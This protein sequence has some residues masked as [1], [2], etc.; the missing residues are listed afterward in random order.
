[1]TLSFGAIRHYFLSSGAGFNQEIGWPNLI[2]PL[3]LE[4]HNIHTWKNAYNSRFEHVDSSKIDGRKV[5][6]DLGI[7][8]ETE[9]YYP[10]N[11]SDSPNIC[12]RAN[13][14]LGKY[15]YKI[16]KPSVQLLKVWIF[17]GIKAYDGDNPTPV[18]NEFAFTRQ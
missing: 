17:I 8:K 18:C 4:D 13:E 15:Q 6:Y 11:P 10:W 5:F 9:F 1:M 14:G 7:G 2:Q 3:N 16:I 12:E